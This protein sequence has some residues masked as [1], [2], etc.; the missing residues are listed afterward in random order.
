MLFR[1]HLPAHT[2]EVMDV[3]STFQL[4]QQKVTA[5]MAAPAPEP[6]A[7]H[8]DMSSSFVQTVN[9]QD[10]TPEALQLLSIHVAKTDSSGEAASKAPAA[11]P[12]AA[13]SNNDGQAQV[14]APSTTD[15]KDVPAVV[16][17][18]S[19]AQP[20]GPQEINTA[21]VSGEQIIQAIASF[22]NNEAH[23]VTEQSAISF[24]NALQQ[25]LAGYFNGGSSLKVVFFES[26][27]AIADIF[28]FAPGVV[29]V[30]EKDISASTH[31]SNNGGNLV[32]D[33]T[34]GTVTL[35]GVATIEHAA[36]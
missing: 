27:N 15:P 21:N 7:I 23:N 20:V 12:V 6:A 1:S 8:V 22:A 34:G 18:P 29:F 35:V 17:P 10:V 25:E 30:A 2:V 32:L 5:M 16:A 19:P 14:T 24:S 33:V 28:A 9:V 3:G 31:L 11:D 36:V 26:T 4:V 13:G